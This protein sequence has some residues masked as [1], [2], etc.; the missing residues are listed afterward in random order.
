MSS[1]RSELVVV[2]EH[3]MGESKN[4]TEMHQDNYIL[5]MPTSSNSNRTHTA[6]TPTLELAKPYRYCNNSDIR[7]TQALLSNTATT[8]TLELAEPYRYC[9]NSDIRVTQALQSNTAT[10]LTLELANPYRYCNNSD[11][12]VTQA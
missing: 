1:V 8:P 6:T 3:Q 10:T 2:L 11:I 9:N 5:L 7:V 12:R 4:L